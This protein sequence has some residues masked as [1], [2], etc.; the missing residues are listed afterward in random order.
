MGIPISRAEMCAAIV[1]GVASE[2]AHAP[3]SSWPFFPLPL[4]TFP[5]VLAKVNSAQVPSLF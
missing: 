2:D 5:E 3:V 1:S 4:V